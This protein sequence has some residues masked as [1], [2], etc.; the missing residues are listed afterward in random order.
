MNPSDK[1]VDSPKSPRY[2]FMCQSCLEWSPSGILTYPHY[3][4]FLN[5]HGRV[6]SSPSPGPSNSLNGYQYSDKYPLKFDLE[7]GI[8]EVRPQ[9]KGCA[10]TEGVNPRG[11]LSEYK[12]HWTTCVEGFVVTLV[13]IHVHTYIIRLVSIIITPCHNRVNTLD[14][15]YPLPLPCSLLTS[16]TKV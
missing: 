9:E 16:Y 3:L 10:V 6:H 2:K 8:F 5:G 1:I 15:P 11:P 7:S 14:K 4:R 13:D 12:E